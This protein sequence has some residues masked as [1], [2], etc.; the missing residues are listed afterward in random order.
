MKDKERAEKLARAIE[1][2]VQGRMPE[3]LDDEE[4]DELLQIAKIRLDA[5]RMAAEAGSEAQATVLERII[6]RLHVQREG[7]ESEPDGASPTSN[8]AGVPDSGDEGPEQLDI[9]ELQDI[10]GLRRQ[11]AEHAAAVSEAHRDAVWQRVQARIQTEQQGRRGFF[12]WPFRR[13]DR[14]ADEFGAALDRMVLG[15]PIWQAENSRLE[16]LLDMAHV[17][18]TAGVSTGG[19]F[20]DQRSRV[21]GRLRPR[22][23]AGL[24]ARQRKTKVFKRRAAMPWGKLAAAGAIVAL[25]AVALGP[26]PATGLAHH[27]V[28]EV[29]RLFSGGD[30]VSETSTPPEVPPVTTV[31]WSNDV[32]AAEAGERLGLPVS[33]PTFVPEGYRLASSEFFPQGI[34]AGD[35][36]L[37]VLAYENTAGT[38]TILVYQ[39]QATANSIAVERGFAQDVTLPSNLSATYVSGSWRPLEGSL[40]WDNEDGQ[41]V[42]FDLSGL[43]TIVHATDGE[44]PLDTLLAVADSL[45]VQVPPP[46]S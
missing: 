13:R 39:E 27:P 45:A 10:I 17:L 35:S 12:R 37:F 41:T 18:R 25:A 22:L 5:A 9:K 16:D 38:G 26:I 28:A 14:D 34:T 11:M 7:D 30:T 43:R 40:L 20:T 3:G 29:A 2:M 46:T 24:M 31:I 4:L 6:A 1:E 8:E 15:E 44:L 36:G 33:E 21:W 19:A 23:I 42:L 32:T